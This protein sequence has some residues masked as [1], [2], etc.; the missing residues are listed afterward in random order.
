MKSAL[1]E[2][3]HEKCGYCEKSLRTTGFEVHHHRPLMNAKSRAG[4]SDVPSP[5]HYAWYAYEWNNLVLACSICA[6]FKGTQFPTQNK[7]VLPFTP[8][9]HADQENPALIDPSHDN[10][11]DHFVFHT[12]GA[13]VFKSPRGKET[14]S[15][16]KLN[17]SEL[18]VMRAHFFSELIIIIEQ[19]RLRDYNEVM[20]A[21]GRALDDRRAHVGAAKIWI[22]DSLLAISGNKNSPVESEFLSEL[23]GFVTISTSAM[24]EKFIVNL[25]GNN[26]SKTVRRFDIIEAAAEKETINFARIVSVQIRN[27][28]GF[29]KFDIKFSSRAVDERDI[30]P[31]VVLLGENAVGKSSLLQAIALG[32]MSRPLREQIKVDLNSFRHQSRWQSTQVANETHTTQASIKVSFD[33]GSV[34]E[35]HIHR[36]GVVHDETFTSTMVLGYGAHRSFNDKPT[37]HKYIKAV[38]SIVSLFNKRRILPHSAEWLESL[39]DETFP[40][41]ARALREILNLADDD[42]IIRTLHSGILIR[43]NGEHIALFQL[44]DGYRSLFAMALDIMRN[45]LRKWGNLESSR[46][47]VLIDEIEIHLHPRWKMQVVSALRGAMPQVQFI[48]TTH[49]PLCLRGMFDGEVHVLLRDDTKKIVELRRLPGVTGM[50]AEQLLTSEYFGLSST[51][52][53]E[54]KSAVDKLLLSDSRSAE[55]QAQFS[56]QLSAFSLI[57]DTPERQVVNEALRRHIVE[58]LR[59]NRLDREDVREESINLIL[60]RLR[61]DSVGVEQ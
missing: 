35:V 58:Q 36:G 52:E 41:V 49:D 23:S 40:T 16:L 21:L 9:A 4:Y 10:P 3:F 53:P 57:G 56:E 55:P 43:K 24:W 29:G 22:A 12:D 17:R 13:C 5:D 46:G 28:K 18:K 8:W 2:T 7:R 26:E 54:I 6:R 47:L 14:I 31:A 39:D 32:T 42:E 33:D 15:V 48:F 30:A 25:K 19:L 50:R 37:S 1:L 45:M 34:N 61:G 44:S 38:S 60:E 20:L 27:F 59:S 51:S 11:Y